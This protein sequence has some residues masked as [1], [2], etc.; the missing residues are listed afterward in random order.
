MPTCPQGMEPMAGQLLSVAGNTALFAMI[1]TTYGGDG[2]T[3]FALPN[4][5]GR[6]PVGT[7]DPRGAGTHSVW[8]AG[9]SSCRPA[10]APSPRSSSLAP[11]MCAGL[12]R[13][14][15]FFQLGVAGGTSRDPL[16][17]DQLPPISLTLQTAFVAGQ[18]V[19]AATSKDRFPVFVPYQQGD[20]P[21]GQAPTPLPLIPRAQR[22]LTGLPMYQPLRY[23]IVVDGMFPTSA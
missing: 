11:H 17:P 4:M 21:V 10:V 3:T 22:P 8:L 18:P 6:F 19:P 15:D 14:G 9:G 23:C 1:G 12:N 2:K 13:D 16:L 20:V 7:G 5:N